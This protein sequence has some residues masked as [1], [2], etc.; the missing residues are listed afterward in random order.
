MMDDVLFEVDNHK[1]IVTLNR[2]N[3]LN[4][5]NVVM[6]VSL[7][8][9][10]QAWAD[11]P[12]IHAIFI[13][14]TTGKAFCAGGDV[15][16]L[17]EAGRSRHRDILAFF[18]QEYQLNQ[19]IY[20]LKKPYIA[21]LDGITMGG[22]VG[23]SLHG[24]YTI[25]TERFQ[26]AMPETTIGFFPDVGGS[27]LLSRCP[28]ALGIYLGLTGS[29][30][31]SEQSFASGLI[32]YRVPS[33]NLAQHAQALIDMDLST[34]AHAKIERYLAQQTLPVHPECLQSLQMLADQY[35][36]AQ[37]VEDIMAS[38]EQQ[39]DP[40]CQ[41]TLALLQLKSPLSLKV[42]LEQLQRAK[43]RSLQACLQQDRRLVAHFIQDHDFYEGVRALLVDKDKCPRWQP[44]SLRDVS[45]QQIANYFTK[46]AMLA[47]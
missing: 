36:M 23:V 47:T 26:F 4:A 34:L 27:Y 44:A 8:E 41:E 28:G 30:L 14:A 40:W 46:T 15:R 1:G 16:W 29:R 25:A 5:L 7:L 10:L 22:G 38:L 39:N 35:F 32:R 21:L 11:D 13:R 18:E 33:N 3:A 37:T 19:M 17:Y 9:Q 42:T 24:R 45:P 6:V 31:N 12:N 2:P 43:S 20:D